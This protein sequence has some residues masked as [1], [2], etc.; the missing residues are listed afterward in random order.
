M[1][2]F[3]IQKYCLDDGPGIRTT[4]FIKGCP[5]SCE[6]CQNPEGQNKEMEIAFYKEKCIYCKEC[7]KV[8]KYSAHVFKNDH[9]HIYIRENCIYCME[10]VNGCPSNALEKVGS[11]KKNEDILKEILEDK[12]FYKFSGGGV[13]FSGG[14]TTF[15]IDELKEIMIMCRKKKVNTAIETCGYFNFADFKSILDYLDLIIYDL[16]FYDYYDHLK[17][18]GVSNKRIFYN[19][20]EISKVFKDIWIRIT[21]LSNI[22]T[23]IDEI[24]HIST[25]MF[26]KL[27]HIIPT[28]NNNLEKF[29]NKELESEK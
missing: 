8:C 21:V 3:N 5:L 27:Y 6:W 1:N 11:D 10:C 19:L 24:K 23:G 16:K 13:T 18:T 20:K 29:L 7:L 17:F 4:V 15:N 26:W 25:K 14:E 22:K 2:I 12:V 9:T 28:F